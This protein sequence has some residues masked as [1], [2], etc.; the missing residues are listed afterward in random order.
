[1]A[2][3]SRVVV[4]EAALRALVTS[5]AGPVVRQILDVRRHTANHART[6]APRDT[7]VLAAS[8]YEE[9]LIHGLVVTG[10]VAI[11]A[12]YGIY[13][14]RGTGIYG[15]SG[16]PIRPK[17][18]KVLAF[19]A[20]RRMG[21]VRAG[22]KT[23]SSGR[24]MVFATQVRGQRPNPFLSRALQAASPWPITTHNH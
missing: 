1:M 8:I 22:A 3:F 17:N 5:P 6:G 15:P 19:P 13:V 12:P 7:G 24:P 10:R 11:A 18:A 20:G 2:G 21:P 23:S 9:L 14:T 4:H 16:Q